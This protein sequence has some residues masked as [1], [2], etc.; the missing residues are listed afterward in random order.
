MAEDNIYQ[1]RRDK[2]EALGRLGIETYPTRYDRSHSVSEAVSEF[3]DESADTFPPLFK[4]TVHNRIYRS[5][6]WRG[7]LIDSVVEDAASLERAK[8]AQH[9]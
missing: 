1:Q 2:L 3:S 8:E 7:V 9:T 5:T 4:L 6:R